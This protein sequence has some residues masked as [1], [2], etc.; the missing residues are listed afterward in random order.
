MNNSRLGGTENC[1]DTLESEASA[2]L[3]SL[4][5]AANHNERSSVTFLADTC[6]TELEIRFDQAIKH[7]LE[8]TY[9]GLVVCRD[10]LLDVLKSAE[11]IG[12]LRVAAQCCAQIG[13]AEKAVELFH[14]II[15]RPDATP[16]DYINLSHSLSALGKH[17]EAAEY[18]EKANYAANLNEGDKSLDDTVSSKKYIKEIIHNYPIYVQLEQLLDTCMR[19]PG[20]PTWIILEA[21][22]IG[23]LAIICAF[24][25][26]FVQTHGHGITLVVTPKFA[27]IPLLWKHRFHRVVVAKADIIATFMGSGFIDQGRFKLDYPM[28]GNFSHLGFQPVNVTKL[29]KLINWPGRGFLSALDRQRFAFRLPWTAKLEKP[30]IP[31][32]WEEEAKKYAEAV[33]LEVGKSVVLFPVNN[34]IPMLPKIF[35]DAVAG[36]LHQMG[37]KIFVNNLGLTRTGRAPL[38]VDNATPIE[39]PIRLALPFVKLAGRAI[40]GSNGMQLLMTLARLNNVAITVLISLQSGLY[41][42]VI[43]GDDG[44]IFSAQNLPL[45]S[46]AQWSSN[47]YQNPEIMTNSLITEFIIP[48]DGS[49]DVLEKLASVVASQDVEHS[50]CFKRYADNGDLFTKKNS[51]WLSELL[52]C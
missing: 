1:R 36:H 13:P 5:G 39:L 44:I 51:K 19:D 47:Q 3:A 27:D 49:P 38:S 20:Y 31:L 18:L 29:G 34:S 33:G 12:L 40:T 26:A 50:A 25:E 42:D 37:Y 9:A 16:D 8:G 46:E 22:S 28:C 11:S 6:K 2:R 45:L 43:N 35:W 4:T 21:Y 52:K 15:L 7:G 10:I 14:R 32:E 48:Y 24:A 17:A 23:E 41:P 30:T